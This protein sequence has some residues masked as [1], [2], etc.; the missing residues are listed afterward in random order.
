MVRNQNK[1]QKI[2]MSDLFV[3]GLIDLPSKDKEKLESF[4]EKLRSEVHEQYLKNYRKN[5]M[6]N[7][8]K[9]LLFKRLSL[10][11]GGALGVAAIAIIP[12]LL[13]N[14]DNKE[15]NNTN[16][17][18]SEISGE[19]AYYEGDL[20]YMNEMGGW[21]DV[22]A[23]LSIKEG[24]NIRMAGMGRAIINLDEGS[25]IRLNN[26]SSIAFTSLDPENIII[27]NTGGEVYTRVVK[28][29]RSFEV[30]IGEN[31]FKSL[32]TAYKTINTETKVGVEVYH[33]KVEIKS[34]SIE[35][36]VVDEG[37]KYYFVNKENTSEQEKVVELKVEE[38]KQD[39]F[40]VWNKDEDKKEFSEE[41]GVLAQ[42]D[43]VDLPKTETVTEPKQEETKE[44][45]AVNPA[46]TPQQ[47]TPTANPSISLGGH[48]DANGINLS[49]VPTNVDVSQG[50][51]VTYNL[52]GNPTYGVDSA[53]YIEAGKTS[54]FL[55]IKD[56]KTYYLRVCRYTGS[57][58]DTYSNQMTIT[59]PVKQVE[60]QPTPGVSSLYISSAGGGAVT[61][62]V[63]G[64][65]Q[66]GFKLV[67]ST[68]PSPTYPAGAGG[69]AG[70]YEA[71]KTSG[72]ITWGGA[73]AGNTYYVRVCEYLNGT[74]GVYSNEITVSL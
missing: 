58:C 20:E 62:S 8:T 40:A 48:A 5:Q 41:L 11:V 4:R 46:P 74:C 9:S 35:K 24:M 50:Y 68:S 64:S 18:S 37:N 53:K 56:G 71:N 59:A 60:P 7:T 2:D 23:N 14:K 44:P 13:T 38:I 72:D 33:S 27:D 49:W 51:K 6:K 57:G 66:Y 3:K 36:K 52:T 65:S 45:V 25:S 10:L 15:N 70:Y 28:A 39:N 31:N 30:N 63:N 32:G 29:D 67:W 19:V 69:S 54:T 73:S 43:T 34:A 16:T 26:N 22:T 47:P 42:L 12:M 17:I 55:D 1:K 61:W 21:A